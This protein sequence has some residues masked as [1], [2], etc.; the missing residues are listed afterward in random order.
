MFN[1]PVFDIA[2]GLIFIFLLYSLL[3]TIIAEMVVEWI[4]LR[5]RM[6]RQA[7]GRMLNDDHLQ[8]M[9]RK[10]KVSNRAA[11]FLLYEKTDF[12]DS[13]AGR[14]YSHP[15]I[16][17]LSSGAYHSKPSYLSNENFAATLIQMMREKGIGET[18]LEKIRFCISNNLLQMEPDTYRQFTHLLLNSGQSVDAFKAQLMLWF[19]NTMDRANGWYKRKMQ[20]ILF[21]VGFALAVCF[22]VD[23]IRIAGILAEDKDARNQLAQLSIQT[24]DTNSTISKAL[25]VSKDSAATYEQLRKSYQELDKARAEANQLLGLGWSKCDSCETAVAGGAV[26]KRKAAAIDVAG[27]VLVKSFNPLQTTFWSFIITALAL[28]LG[29]PFWFDLLRK[30][31]SIR[32]AGVKPEEKV[33]PAANTTSAVV[34]TAK[35]TEQPTAHSNAT[36]VATTLTT[37]QFIEIYSRE[38]Q[39]IAGVIIIRKYFY[40]EG[41]VKKSGVQVNVKTQADA[42]KVTNQYGN[43]CAKNNIRLHTIINTEAKIQAGQINTA[44]NPNLG[45]SNSEL[46]HGWGS[47]GFMAKGIANESNYYLVTCF[48]VLNGSYNWY[49]G[50]QNGQIQNFN[51]KRIGTSFDG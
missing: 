3:A 34:V 31:V 24:A 1:S 51:R 48:H 27:C 17:Y 35:P 46:L 15:S 23:C 42:D 5:A 12:N 22:N 45:I 10:E 9:N 25:Y 21:W 38:I 13:L 26:V 36:M 41:S 19:D 47:F 28:T 8:T 4:G 30:L 37:D 43:L 44:T 14:F 29:A 6:L 11:N 2:L 39:S 49:N 18:D 33:T 50:K 16:N 32:S 20:L 40:L 7:I